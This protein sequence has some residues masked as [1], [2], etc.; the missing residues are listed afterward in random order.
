MRKP[1][2]SSTLS[3]C[4][5]LQEF[6]YR[7]TDMDG[8]GMMSS[9]LQRVSPMLTSERPVTAQMSPALT[10]STGTLLKLLKTNSSATLPVR[11]RSTSAVK[12]N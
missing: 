2:E 1:L 11:D 4:N 10:S 12:A 6:I 8:K 3:K 9:V 5:S 7:P